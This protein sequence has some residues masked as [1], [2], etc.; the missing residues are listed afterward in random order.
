MS[1]RLGLLTRFAR[2]G[3]SWASF[4]PHAKGSKDECAHIVQPTRGCVVPFLVS[5]SPTMCVLR[6]RSVLPV[7]QHPM[8]PFASN[9]MLPA[10]TCK[11]VLCERRVEM[12]TQTNKPTK[13]ARTCSINLTHRICSAEK[14]P[15]AKVCHHRSRRLNGQDSLFDLRRSRQKEATGQSGNPHRTPAGI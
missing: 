9:P 13:K 7:A 4:C 12:D 10:H 8:E 2:G 14:T 6:S 11:Q 1:V 5:H 15:P 3:S